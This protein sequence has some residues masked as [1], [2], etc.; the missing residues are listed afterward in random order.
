VVGMGQYG[1]MNLLEF[2]VGGDYVRVK[3]ELYDYT[4]TR[5]S[6]YNSVVS[7]GV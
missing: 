3:N 6:S 1:N 5:L 2:P 7:F 4:G